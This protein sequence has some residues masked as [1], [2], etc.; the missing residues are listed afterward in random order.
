MRSVAVRLIEASSTTSS[1]T[2]HPVGLW[3]AELRPHLANLMGSGGFHALLSRALALAKEDMPCLHA[4]QVSA[5]GA[6]EVGDAESRV[7]SKE[8]IEASVVLL[9]HLFGLLVAF[10]GENLTLQLVHEIWPKLLLRNFE[11][12]GEEV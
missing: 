5:T 3:I 1:Q 6:L 2:A 4:V 7:D 8:F 12:D 9:A 11:F 10:I